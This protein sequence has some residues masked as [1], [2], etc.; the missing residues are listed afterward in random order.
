M[1]LGGG[2]TQI[3]FEPK[4]GDFPEGPHKVT[5]PFM[6]KSYSL[7]QKSYDGYGLK[8]GLKKSNSKGG[9]AEK[10]V[11]TCASLLSS[12]FDKEQTCHLSPC[13]FNGVYM[14]RLEDHFYDGDIYAFSY[15]YDVFAEP[16]DRVETGFKVGHIHEAFNSTCSTKPEHEDCLSLGFIYSLLKVGY[17]LPHSRHL[18]TAKKIDGIETG[19]CLGAALAMLH[20]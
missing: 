17:D 9:C 20:S 1:D 7:Y 6:D 15:F 13:S 16:F 19:W 11:A 4:F 18:K 14:P 8:Q 2:S 10:P 5:I 12:L 3:V